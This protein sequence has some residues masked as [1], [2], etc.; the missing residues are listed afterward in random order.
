MRILQLIDSLRPGGAEQMAVNFANSFSG[1]IVDSHLCCTRLEGSL[2]KKIK[3]KENYIFL[4]RKNTFDLK[5]I[6]KLKN[7]INFYKIDLIHAHGSSFF[8]GVLIKIMIPNTKLVWHDHLGARALNNKNSGFLKFAS[9]FFD[10][11]I[12]VNQ[13]LYEWTKKNLFCKEVLLLKNFVRLEDPSSIDINL[14]GNNDIN[15]ICVA[16]LR[17]PKD[18]ITLLKA[19]SLLDQQKFS[20]SLHLVGNN[21]DKNYTA[22]LLEFIDDNNLKDNVFMY[23]QK[24]NINSLLHLASIGVL[25]SSS[26]GLPMALLEYGLA[27]LP[28]VCTN[29]GD[30]KEVIGNY[31]KVVEQENPKA[32]A[33]GI[34]YYLR[35]PEEMK[36][37][38]NNFQKRIIENYSEKNSIPLVIEFFQSLLNQNKR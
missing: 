10:G 15:I 17:H 19:F 36:K 30:I 35:N 26:E 6:L 34:T 24:E 31:G 38:A 3:N 16:N 18:H 37:D 8:L 12:V 25:S 23:G 21:S 4:N 33:A 1:E 5:A 13:D 22:K 2:K 28:V 29:V 32:F 14:R 9:K 11:I 20:L 7:Y 27:G